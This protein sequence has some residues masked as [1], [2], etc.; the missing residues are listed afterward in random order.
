[1]SLTCFP[2]ETCLKNAESDINQIQLLV[3]LELL[4]T[5]RESSLSFTK[6]YLGHKSR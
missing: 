2:D 1:M 5:F 4:E 6:C 3:I